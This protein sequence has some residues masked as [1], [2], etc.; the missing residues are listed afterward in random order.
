MCRAYEALPRAHHLETSR[1]ARLV[2]QRTGHAPMRILGHTSPTSAEVLERRT[3]STR[4]G[5]EERR[6]FLQR[7]LGV[8]VVV[9]RVVLPR[10]ALEVVD[11]DVSLAIGDGRVDGLAR[12]LVELRPGGRVPAG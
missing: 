6:G 3:C 9:V 2:V 12:A 7:E 5:E 11:R 1:S 10:E 8:L 4:P